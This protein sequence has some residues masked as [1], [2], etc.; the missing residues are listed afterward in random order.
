MKTPKIETVRSVVPMIYAYTT[1]GI[2]YHD[3]YIKIGY[4]EQ[5]VDERIKQQTHTAGVAAQKEW[6]GTAIYDDGTGETFKD[7]EFHA[8]LRGNGV[9]QPQD[10]NNPYFDPKDR[11]EWFF[12]SP[13]E[14][15]GHFVDFK[16][17]R[18][19]AVSNAVVIPYVLRKEQAEAVEK[20]AAYFMSHPG[21]EFLWNCKPRF[22]KC[23]GVYDLVRTMDF[24][25]VL[26]VTNR[27]AIANSWL[28]DYL[29]FVGTNSKWY[30]VS[31]TDAL[32]GRAGVV[33]R[34]EYLHH[35]FGRDK[36]EKKIGCIEFV[37][38]QDMK[39]SKYFSSHGIDKLGEVAEME[40]DLLVVDES[41]E[42]VDTYKTDIAFEQIHRRFTIHLSGTPFKAI[43]SAKFP[44]DA[45]FNWTYA[46]EQ[47]AK[48]NWDA[49]SVTENPYAVLP[50]INLYTYQ[51]SE[52]IADQLQRGIEIQ[53]ETEEYA[54]DLNEFFATDGNGRFKYNDSVDHFLDAL[55]F[56]KRFP[57]STQELR[58]EL[59]HTFWLLNRVDSA[60]ALAKKLREHPIF[61]DY[62]VVLAAGDGK[63]D[64]EDENKKSYDKVIHAIATHDKTITLSVG[65]LTVGVTVP[66]WTAVLILSNVKSPALYMQAAFRAQNPC[67]FQSGTNCYRKENA[68]VFDFDPARSLTIYEEFANDLIPSTAAGRGD[69][70]SRKA[71][72]R[73]F[74][75]FFPVIGED[76]D[77]ELVALD[78]E[79]V[80]TLPRKIRSIEVVRRGFLSNFLFANISNIFNAPP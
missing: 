35:I 50:Q 42:G 61:H 33:S 40:W 78:A 74:L 48:K 65:Q 55:T 28:A 53:G 4:T 18:G 25:K 32:K 56:Q 71:N 29:Q 79:Q 15:R 34:D 30:F 57:F 8:Y 68:Y 38:L 58:D 5:N 12:V 47:Q 23:L 27:P 10:L 7:K 73:Q 24:T 41:H 64:D 11:N 44:V 77:G 51:M 43:A 26:I 60:K 2:T 75:N 76:E 9:R 67:L 1:P 46:D 49:T 54:F 45:I 62:E 69:M 16:S 21:G 36:S 6:Q 37:S 14:S 17:N 13:S 19:S 3:G 63:I 20:A 31:S 66:E 22:G 72:I 52:V 59:K 80:L 70:E 39:G